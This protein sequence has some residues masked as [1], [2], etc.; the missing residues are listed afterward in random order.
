MNEALFYTL[1]FTQKVALFSSIMD[2]I[3]VTQK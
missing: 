3:M 1:I 2:Q